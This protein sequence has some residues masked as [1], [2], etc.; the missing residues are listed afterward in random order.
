MQSCFYIISQKAK[1]RRWMYLLLTSD[2]L[3][4][5][6][7]HTSGAV[8]WRR[9]P[10]ATSDSCLSMPEASRNLP[11]GHPKAKRAT[12]CLMLGPGSTPAGSG[13]WRDSLLYV[14]GPPQGGVPT[15][16]R[17]TLQTVVIQPGFD[18]LTPQRPPVTLP[19]DQGSYPW[20]IWTSF[21]SYKYPC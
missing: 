4:F 6:G 11:Q 19:L 20:L 14:H 15:H 1:E 8:G 17:V 5:P 9:M 3:K 21:H 2:R 7:D 13:Q 10:V 18:P 12:R 16:R